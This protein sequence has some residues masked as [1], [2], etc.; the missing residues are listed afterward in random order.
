MR[1]DRE[2][3]PT[4]PSASSPPTAPKQHSERR[5][6]ATRLQILIA[7]CLTCLAA[8]PGQTQT[9]AA[10]EVRWTE[11]APGVEV[12]LR[13]REARFDDG[14]SV[15]LTGASDVV[16][17]DP[18]MDPEVASEWI[19]RTRAEG[20]TVRWIIAT[21]WH[22]DHNQTAAALL[23]AFP[24]ATLLG[25]TT[26]QQ[27][28][29][30]RVEGERD[31]RLARLEEQIPAAK[32][33]LAEGRGM[34]GQEL[35]AEQ[36]EGQRQA[37]ARAEAWI[38]ANEGLTF[39]VPPL[40]LDGDAVLELGDSAI[41]LRAFRAHTDGD[42][43]VLLPSVRLA[44][45]GDLLDELPFVGHGAPRSWIQALE[46]IE[47][48]PVDTFIPGHGDPFGKDHLRAVRAF[49]QTI[50]D[51]VDAARTAGDSEDTLVARVA[52]HPQILAHRERLA[53]DAPAERFFDGTL[54]AAIRAAWNETEPIP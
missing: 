52:D 12:A 35:D 51:L 16:V 31:A 30:E 39:A 3:R 53:T 21:H 29:P 26:L 45:T 18:P 4:V 10:P 14:N 44:L 25:H 46:Q 9:A 41:E 17:V 40:G 38:Q 24:D 1:P 43:V 36:L 47:G 33:A 34:S 7:A 6:D 8:H 19:R 20:R 23:A 5:R 28:I 22:S 32:A 37:I 11:I 49:L 50:V 48:W 42:L 54:E 27:A 15:R 2:P 13:P